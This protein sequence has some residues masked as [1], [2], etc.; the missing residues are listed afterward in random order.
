MRYAPLWKA[1]TTCGAATP[2]SF[3]C[4]TY[5]P[6]AAAS[7][8]VQPGS[9]RLPSQVI[10]IVLDACGASVFVD[11]TSLRGH[12]ALLPVVQNRSAPV[13]T[14]QF[15]SDGDVV[16]RQDAA[17]TLVRTPVKIGESPGA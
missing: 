1:K 2:S 3:A 17:E 11:A 13:V 12:P 5:S 6:T 4:R 7:P 9:R 16:R 10:E 14:V 15:S 8:E